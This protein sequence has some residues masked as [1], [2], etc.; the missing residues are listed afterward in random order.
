MS[1]K[2]L[3]TCI[4]DEEVF[5]E[6]DKFC[7]RTGKKKKSTFE[8]ALKLYLPLVEEKVRNREEQKT[9]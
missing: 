9:N 3:K 6:L 8:Q 7:K 5:N 1:K 2:E 4:I